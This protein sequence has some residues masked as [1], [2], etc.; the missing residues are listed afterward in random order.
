M[1]TDRHMVRVSVFSI[2]S[3][4]VRALPVCWRRCG[5]A[6]ALT[7]TGAAEWQACLAGV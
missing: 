7:A 5:P 4:A 3:T 2:V 1:L 6:S